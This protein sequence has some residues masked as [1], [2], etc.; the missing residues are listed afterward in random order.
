MFENGNGGNWNISW[1]GVGCPWNCST[2]F[3]VIRFH[4][5]ALPFMLW[6]IFCANADLI[7]NSQH[8]CHLVQVFVLFNVL[9]AIIVDA[10]QKAAG[11]ATEAPSMAQDAAA[12]IKRLSYNVSGCSGT[13]IVSSDRLL[14]ATIAFM[15]QV[16][17]F[18][19]KALCHILCKQQIT[20][21][22][23][24][25]DRSQYFWTRPSVWRW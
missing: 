20:N 3:R 13:Q 7:S 18:H 12:A 9:L 2:L 16:R 15:N 25:E 10:Y 1:H 17:S 11:E 19:G 8:E 4:C 22:D 6:I 5:G 21:D 23:A 24:G 14:L